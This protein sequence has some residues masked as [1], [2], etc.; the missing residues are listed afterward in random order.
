MRGPNVSKGCAR[1]VVSFFFFT[2]MLMD[3]V[4]TRCYMIQFARFAPLQGVGIH[5]HP[6]ISVC[7]CINVFIRSH[8]HAHRC[9]DAHNF[10][11]IYAWQ[12]SLMLLL[13]LRF[14]F[15]CVLVEPPPPPTRAARR[16]T[17]GQFAH[18]LARVRET[19]PQNNAKSIP[20]CRT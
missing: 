1:V 4:Y 14:C 2:D 7:V 3:V 20:K 5:T 15:L 6:H 18:M 9:K 13:L 16:A 17:R 12:W 11:S 19:R 10:S 8:A